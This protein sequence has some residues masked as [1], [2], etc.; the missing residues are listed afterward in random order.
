MNE[1]IASRPT[2]EKCRPDVAC[3]LSRAARYGQER[4][5][6]DAFSAHE[7]TAALHDHFEV[8]LRRGKQ[9]DVLERIAVD[10]Q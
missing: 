3:N 8:L 10:D 6:C 7:E 4:V 2:V 5:V 1:P 9:G